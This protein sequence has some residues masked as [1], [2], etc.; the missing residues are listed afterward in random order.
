MTEA[1][2]PPDMAGVVERLERLASNDDLGQFARAVTR[3]SATVMRSDLRALLSAFNERGERLRYL[4]GMVAQT[5]SNVCPVDPVELESAWA[6]IAAR[7][8][9]AGGR[10]RE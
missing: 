1:Q 5:Q 2:S 3:S 8:P 4:G 9:T 7:A 6:A 10:G